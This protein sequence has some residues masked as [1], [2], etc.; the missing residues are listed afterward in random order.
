MPVH[1]KRLADRADAAVHHVAW[2]DDIGT[3]ISLI[4][5]LVDQH[6]NGFVVQHIACIIDQSVLSVRGIGVESDVGQH[7]DF[8]FM[9]GFNRADCLAHQ[10]VGVK[11]L[12]AIGA[13]TVG[14]GVGKQRN[15]RDA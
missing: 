8:V 1:F 9:R 7:A 2:G 10:I 14:W 5:R 3:G 13:A 12:T 15:A 6:S 4:D 11:R